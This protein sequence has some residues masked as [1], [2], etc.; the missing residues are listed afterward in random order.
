MHAIARLTVRAFL[1]SLDRPTLFFIL[2]FPAFFIFVMSF[3]FTGI[4]PEFVV[5]GMR[6][7]YPVFLASGAVTFTV[8]N[9][10]MT[11]G[12]IVWFDRKYGMY[13]QIL[14]GP[15]RRYEYL[16]SI[17]IATILVSLVSA[18]LAFLIALPVLIQ[19]GLTPTGFLYA[20]LV[21]VAG[22]ILFGSLALILSM[23]VKSSESFQVF[24]SFIFFI[25]LFTSSVFYPTELAPEPIRIASLLNPLTYLADIFRAGLLGLID[26]ILAVKI[27]VLTAESLSL[28]ILAVVL[29]N[30]IRV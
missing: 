8:V 13:E 1:S 2:I 26:P 25:I 18:G 4:I 29:F 21:L 11:V 14:M 6:L 19:G 27:G 5:G 30:R 24:N 9:S 12:V 10:G 17:I 7:S 23:K 20:G 22:S 28:L 16:A 15:F 3:A